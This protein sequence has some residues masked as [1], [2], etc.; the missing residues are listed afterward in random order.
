MSLLGRVLRRVSGGSRL[1]TRYFSSLVVDD[2][3]VKQLKRIDET[4][5]RITVDGG[6]C[7]GFQYKFELDGTVH[8]DDVVTEKDGIKIITDS[9]S[10]DFI[11]GSTVEFHEELIR[12]AFRIVHNPQADAGC[13]CGVSFSVK[14]D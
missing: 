10:L 6:G 12:S 13:S 11:K 1:I 7:S 4:A 9:I 14:I 3:A 5:L 2:S 8:E